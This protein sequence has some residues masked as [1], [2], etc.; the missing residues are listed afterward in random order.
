M[1]YQSSLALLSQVKSVAFGIC[2]VMFTNLK[3]ASPSLMLPKLWL[4]ICLVK[5][6]Y[7]VEQDHFIRQIWVSQCVCIFWWWYPVPLVHARANMKLW[8]KMASKHWPE[9]HAWAVR[10]SSA[11]I[12]QKLKKQGGS[13]LPKMMSLCESICVW[14]AVKHTSDLC[15]KRPSQCRGSCLWN[16]VITDQIKSAKPLFSL[17]LLFLNCWRLLILGRRHHDNYCGQ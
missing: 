16:F 1:S 6:T 11:H 8:P 9:L 2:Y 7:N 13:K 14:H 4:H 10:C 17:L 5:V 12:F 3:T 15:V